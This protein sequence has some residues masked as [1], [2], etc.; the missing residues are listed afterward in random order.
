MNTSPVGFT[1][2]TASQLVRLVL[3]HLVD[4]GGVWDPVAP[5]GLPTREVRNA[6]YCL[7]DPTRCATWLPER[8]LNYQFMVAEFL[9]IFC[10]RDDVAMIGYYNENIKKFSDDGA[11]F[12]G[13]YGPRWRGQIAGVLANL[14]GDDTSRQ[15]VVTY[16][17]PEV[18]WNQ[19]PDG[20]GGG[21]RGRPYPTTRDVPC[22]LTTQY[23]WRLGQ[24]EAITT[25]RSSDAWLGLPYDIYNQAM[26]QRALA[27]ELGVRAGPLTLHIGSSHL[28]ERDLARAREVL[29]GPPASPLEEFAIPGPPGL[30]MNMI[31]AAEEF[32]RNDELLADGQLDQWQEMLSCLAYRKHRNVSRVASPYWMLMAGTL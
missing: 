1:A 10:G 22:T 8:K 28:Y 19:G 18:Y 25:M 26:L 15:A 13:A 14:R 30:S 21:G 4:E 17:R 20:I 7:L 31:M 11:T 2:S 12:F 29:A 32:Q 9:W 24:L 27:A 16:W 23:L 3:G 5:R 6:V